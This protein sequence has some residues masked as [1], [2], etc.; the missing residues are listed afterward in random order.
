MG[1]R[2]LPKKEKR[3]SRV[4]LIQSDRCD[5]ALDPIDALCYGLLSHTYTDFLS[6]NYDLKL[7]CPDRRRWLSILEV[8]INSDLFRSVY[9]R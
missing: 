7:H 5:L 3:H 1:L 4:L 2:G 6:Y 9:N 8:S